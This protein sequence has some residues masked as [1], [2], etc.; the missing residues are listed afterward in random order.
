MSYR[1]VANDHSYVVAAKLFVENEIRRA[2]VIFDAYCEWFCQPIGCKALDESLLIDM[3]RICFSVTSFNIDTLS[4]LASALFEAARATPSIAVAARVASAI[5]RSISSDCL[6]LVSFV[7]FPR[8]RV[9]VQSPAVTEAN[10]AVTRARATV[11]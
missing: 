2:N 5:D 7:S 8:L 11:E 9:A 1:A 4:L 3:A 6:A 10:I